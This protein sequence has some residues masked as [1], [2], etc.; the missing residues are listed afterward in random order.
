[1]LGGSVPLTRNTPNNR[2]ASA[3]LSEFARRRGEAPNLSL[4]TA[5]SAHKSDNHEELKAKSL[6]ESYG[7]LALDKHASVS[8][9]DASAQ[10]SGSDPSITVHR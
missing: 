5:T 7:I 6:E 2:R 9:D 4:G 8:S 3:A 10:G 1:M